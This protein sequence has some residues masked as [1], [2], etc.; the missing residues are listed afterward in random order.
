MPIARTPEE[1]LAAQLEKIKREV[2]DFSKNPNYLSW[3]AVAGG[4]LAD[5]VIAYAWSKRMAPRQER[6]HQNMVKAGAEWPTVIP[7]GGVF[8]GLQDIALN[9][10]IKQIQIRGGEDAEKLQAAISK[11]DAQAR[12]E[13]KH[14]V[15]SNPD[16][17][18]AIANLA[19][20][21]NQ[22]EEDEARELYG[23]ANL[24]SWL[25]DAAERSGRLG[26]SEEKSLLEEL[27]T[28]LS[29]TARFSPPGV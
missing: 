29:V 25:R 19:L 14:R 24:S 9:L 28:K 20:A 13:A 23:I 17:L 4:N 15:E 7:V 6:F 10:G 2:T 27:L 3:E 11:I 21:G 12:F 18:V 5:V 16:V 8:E 22:P 26:H 1:A